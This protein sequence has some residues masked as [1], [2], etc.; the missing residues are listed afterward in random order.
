M[1]FH[2][3]TVDRRGFRNPA[4]V[5]AARTNTSSAA[6]KRERPRPRCLTGNAP[7]PPQGRRGLCDAPKATPNNLDGS[8]RAL[9]VFLFG[10]GDPDGAGAM[11]DGAS[12]GN[13]QAGG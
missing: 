4:T 6:S 5:V 10:T 11:H 12:I 1:P 13:V 7:G 3:G 2:R 8:Y 9:R